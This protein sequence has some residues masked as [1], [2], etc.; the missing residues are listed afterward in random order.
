V[1]HK[2]AQQVMFVCPNLETGG[3]ERQWAILIRGLFEQ[4]FDVNVLTLDGRG[5]YFDELR[6]AG[7]PIACA[8]LRHRA[9]P[10]GLAR[11]AWL[12]RSWSSTVVTRG[13]SAHMVGHVLAQ[14]HRA[15]HVLT[16]HSVAE[17]ARFGPPRRHQQLLIKPIRPRANC[18]VAVTA[19]QV[20][21]LVSEGY[22]RDAI[23][24][25]ANGVA[26]DPPVRDRE[27]VRAE[28]GVSRGDF[29]AVLMAW[30]RPEKRV[31]A[32]V[33]QVTVAHAIETRVKGLVV[34]DGPDYALVARATAESRGVVRMLGERADALDIM[35][36][37]DVVCLT[38]VAET[39][40]MSVLEAMS[41]GRPVIATRV[42]GVP[43][44]V[45]D[46]ETGILVSPDCPSEVATAL[47][48]LARDPAGATELGSAGRARQQ[49]SFSE[50]AMT[51]AYAALLMD[52]GRRNKR[53]IRAGMPEAA[54]R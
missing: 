42:G 37:A 25:I 16:E 34:G 51:R 19:S 4:G 21:Y 12:G 40:P 54:T 22:P 45:R 32:F 35:H 6:A 44:A 23:R 49:R 29:L 27:A 33:E 5:A 17:H 13:L 24:V 26:N 38:S 46:G 52:V 28:L 11:A 14:G 1:T 2:S 8:A 31:P 3:A 36:A 39:L 43:E 15:A 48:S 53:G 30:L 47:V 18:V 50:E 20:E 10:V 9:D 7:V 41:V